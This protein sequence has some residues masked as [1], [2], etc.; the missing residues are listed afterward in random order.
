MF[1]A[2]VIID[3]LLALVL[4]STGGGKLWQLPS[5]LAIRDS[6]LLSNRLWR[7]IGALEILG[8]VGLTVGIW[9]PL[10]GLLASGGIA[11]LMVGALVARAR[12]RQKNLGPY[13][14]DVVILLVAVAALVLHAR[15]L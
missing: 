13:I 6:L 11:L 7:A 10:T 4:L 2:R 14:A 1:T 12:V 3:V 15:A 9:V 8:V 5:S